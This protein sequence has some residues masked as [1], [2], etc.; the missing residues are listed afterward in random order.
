MIEA[1]TGVEFI[2]EAHLTDN[3][4]A[5]KAVQSLIQAVSIGMTAGGAYSKGLTYVTAGKLESSQVTKYVT[6]KVMKSASEDGV[7]NMVTTE[8]TEHDCG[9]AQMCCF[10]QDCMWEC[11]MHRIS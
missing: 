3:E 4:Q 7:M 2:T 8:L 11:R 10:L 5:G 1:V 9:L 6:C